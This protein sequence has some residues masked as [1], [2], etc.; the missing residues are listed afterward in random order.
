M[1]F[2]NNQSVGIHITTARGIEVFIPTGGTSH[3]AQMVMA[4]SCFSLFSLQH[5]RRIQVAGQSWHK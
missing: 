3:S 5:V 1:G 2:D 4:I